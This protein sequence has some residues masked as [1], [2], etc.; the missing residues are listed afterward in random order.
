MAQIGIHSLITNGLPKLTRTPLKSS[1]AFLPRMV[2]CGCVP[3]TRSHWSTS[4]KSLRLYSASWGNVHIPLHL[5]GLSEIFMTYFSC[6]YKYHLF[7]TLLATSHNFYLPT[8]LKNE[9]L[10]GWRDDSIRKL[11]A[12]QVWRPEVHPQ[13][14][15]RKTDKVA[16]TVISALEQQRQ[17][18]HGELT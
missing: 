11:L 17:E 18:D 15:V 12:A 9:T 14:H 2:H 10:G 5:W 16:C 3:S 7:Y 4:Q 8:S 6:T 1:E 13:T